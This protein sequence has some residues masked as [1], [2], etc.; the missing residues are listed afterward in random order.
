MLILSAQF[1]TSVA[2]TSDLPK[3]KP[4][5]AIA[6][7]SNVGKSSFINYICNNRKLARTSKDP[8]R[9]RLLN[10]FECNKG[11][12]YLVDL[13]GYGYAK[14]S[15]T[16]K[17]KWAELLENYFE[18]SQGLKHV[19]VI[20]DIRH[21]PTDDDMDLINYLYYYNIPFSIIASKSDKLS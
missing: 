9:T 1:L 10:Y 13:P 4:E 16:E 19:F 15:Y 11:K 5:I 20:V 21:N 17:R 2:K 18:K 6:G 12:F 3:G 8:G 7:K 14:V